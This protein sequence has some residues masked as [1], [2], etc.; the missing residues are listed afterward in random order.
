MIDGKKDFW[1]RDASKKREYHQI[2]LQGCEKSGR[3]YEE[4]PISM[5]RK[6]KSRAKRPQESGSYLDT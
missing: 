4:T 5:K 3:F 1:K 2:L 6:K